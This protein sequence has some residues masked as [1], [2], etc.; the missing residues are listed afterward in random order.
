MAL[1]IHPGDDVAVALRAIAKG[2]EVLGVTAREDIPAG[3]KIALRRI[4][5]GQNVIKYA[6]PIGHATLDIAP[7]DWVHTHNVATNLDGTLAYRYEPARLPQARPFSGSFMGYPRPDGR[8]GVRNEIWIVTTVACVNKTAE[9]L[10]ALANEKFAGRT[11]GVFCFP[12]PY[13]CSQMGDDL[14]NTQKL[15][16]AMVKSPNAGG[17]LVLSLGCENNHLGVFKPM[18]GDVDE[19]R[20]KFLTT[21]EVGDELHAGLSLIGQIVESMGSDARCEQPISKLVVG[22]K[23]GGSDGFSGITANPLLGAFSDRLCAA[24]G[25][26]VLTEVP[27]MFGA[28]TILMNR[29][30]DERVFDKTVRMINGYKEYFIA[31]GQVVYENPSP[32]NK[33]GGITTLEDKSL[34]CTQKGGAGPVV[35]VLGYAEPARTPGLNLL[36]GPGNDGCAIT[37]L[38][39][40]HCH[41]ILFT[42]GRGTPMG[43]PVPTLKLATNS[44]M[45]ERKR[46]WIDFDAGQLL[47]GLPMDE[48]AE[49]LKALALRVASGEPAQNERNGY[50]EIA[51][52]K[53]G[54]TV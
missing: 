33:Q 15:L 31:H 42:T 48:A 37:A 12:H 32:G 4:P 23:C 1:R 39:A 25:T 28:E 7:G 40:S 27:E 19:R 50:R 45:A 5:K 30:A 34:G 2:E 54:V 35:D 44:E 41:L 3:H 43:A 53:D 22:L 49:R 26:S 51:I 8:V 14:K 10:C 46:H 47:S 18:L 9:R 24:G 36:Y 29:C 52:W 38:M 13:G 17:A 11:D 16:A 21:Q 6:F 20:V